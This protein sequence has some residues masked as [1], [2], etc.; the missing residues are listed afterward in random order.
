MLTSAAV[1]VAVVASG[2]AVA[3]ATDALMRV[4]RLGL[5]VRRRCMA[6]DAGKA[7]VVR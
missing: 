6:V 5:L 2:G 4:V 7:R 1:L 3:I